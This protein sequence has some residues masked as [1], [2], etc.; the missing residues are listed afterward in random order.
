[1]RAA[2]S[3]NKQS[4]YAKPKAQISYAVAAQ[5]ISTIVFITS[6]YP[7]SVAVQSGLCRTWPRGY[8][9]FFMLSSAETKFILL[10]NVKMPTIVGKML[11]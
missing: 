8:K 5:L 1:M 7:A 4:A 2:A 6:F 11:K 3:E 10:I 9:T